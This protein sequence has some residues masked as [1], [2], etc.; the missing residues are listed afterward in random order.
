V[1]EPPQAKAE[2]LTH[3][4]GAQR[5]QYYKVRY[6]TQ[7][8]LPTTGTPAARAPALELLVHAGYLALIAARVPRK[9]LSARIKPSNHAETHQW[10]DFD[11]A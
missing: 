2:C 3:A 9:A 4:R 10:V 5:S 11:I 6:L 8:R 7:R 1:N